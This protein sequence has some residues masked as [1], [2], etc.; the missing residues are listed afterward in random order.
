MY[1]LADI[2]FIDSKAERSCCDDNRDRVLHPVLLY[3]L[4]VVLRNICCVSRHGKASILQD[5]D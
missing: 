4:P 3:P 2:R 1:H 5:M